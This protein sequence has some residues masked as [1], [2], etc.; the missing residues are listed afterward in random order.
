MAVSTCGKCNGHSFE[1]APFAPLG[2]NRK[3]A[4]VQC[5][6]CGAPIGVLDS[7]T[8][9]QIDGLKSQIAAIDAGLNR[10]VKALQ[11]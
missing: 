2:T 8:G 10:I 3:F 4:M 11:N 7:A 6:G 9:A 1:L 5:S